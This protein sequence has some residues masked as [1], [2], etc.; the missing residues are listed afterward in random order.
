MATIQQEYNQFL[1]RAA[2]KFDEPTHDKCTIHDENE[3]V[4]QP[5][6]GLQALRSGEAP[7]NRK[8]VFK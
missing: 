8:P 7:S 3:Q 2:G 5:L 1:L 6:G 4:R